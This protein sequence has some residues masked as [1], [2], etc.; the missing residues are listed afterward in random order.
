[1]RG[2]AE[3]AAPVAV[4]MLPAVALRVGSVLSLPSGHILLP[5]HLPR[6]ITQAPVAASCYTPARSF[7]RWRSLPDVPA[8]LNHGALPRAVGAPFILPGGGH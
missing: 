8:N 3:A 4:F 2:A 5:W 7:P 1:M 6:A